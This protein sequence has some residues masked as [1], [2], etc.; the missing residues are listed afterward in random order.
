MLV[1]GTPGVRQS[2]ESRTEVALFCR[3]RATFCGIDRAR[4]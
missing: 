2:A 4:H 1:A 3:M